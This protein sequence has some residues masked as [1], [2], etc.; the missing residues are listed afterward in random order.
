MAISIIQNMPNT[1]T[2]LCELHLESRESMLLA[3]SRPTFVT[4]LLEATVK[5][6]AEL[7]FSNSYGLTSHW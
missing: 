3:L 1:F 2:V 4:I 6:Q 5:L 7:S